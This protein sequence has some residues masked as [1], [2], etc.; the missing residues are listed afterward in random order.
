M[1]R[2]QQG[3][4]AAEGIL[5]G[6]TPAR[7]G[8]KAEK[9]KVPKDL[10]RPEV[11]LVGIDGNAMSIIAVVRKALQ[12]EGNSLDVINAFT[13]EAMSGDYDHVLQAA[14]A[15]TETALYAE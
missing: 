3:A 15:Y 14:L 6:K 9:I 11:Q 8:T 12:K 7:S 2:G 13:E 1:G 4:S 10:I 5:Y